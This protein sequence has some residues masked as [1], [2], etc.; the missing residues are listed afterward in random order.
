MEDAKQ[1]IDK[2]LSTNFKWIAKELH[3]H[4][5]F[6]YLRAVS[7]GLQEFIE[8]LTF[9][10]YLSESPSSAWEDVQQRMLYEN[11]ENPEE[12]FSLTMIPTE[13]ILGYADLTGHSLI[14]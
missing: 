4:D 8:A 14:L 13:F 3:G 2:L 7:P 1:R 12:K 6:L 11:E 10:E 9:Y 5:L